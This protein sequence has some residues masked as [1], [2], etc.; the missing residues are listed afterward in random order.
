MLG[1]AGAVI[2]PVVGFGAKQAATKMRMDQLQNLQDLIALGRAPTVDTRTK[3]IPVTGLRG[4]LST[5]NQ[6][7]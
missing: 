1:P 6:S 3:F 7:E 5:T 2:A 4:L